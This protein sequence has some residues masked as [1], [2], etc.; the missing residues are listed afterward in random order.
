MIFVKYIITVVIVVFLSIKASHYV[1]L[2]D[3]KTNL[4]GAFLGGIMLSAVTS[5]PE[6]FTSL[7]S[8]FLVGEP[9]MCLG[10][11]LGSDLFNLAALATIILVYFKGFNK[12]VFSASYRMVA[13]AVL[14]IYV[15]LGLNF[16]GAINFSVFTVSLTS[17]FIIVTYAVGVKYLSAASD[18]ISDEEELKIQASKSSPLSVKQVG[19]RFFF[20]GLGII[21]FSILL[22][23]YTDQVAERLNIGAGFAGALFLGIATSLPEVTSTITL[24]KMKNYNIAIGNIIGSNLFNF[25][26]LAL[27]DVISLSEDLY[28][29]PDLQIKALEICGLIAMP[30]F[31]VLI[32]TRNKTLRAACSV[33]IIG[34]YLAFLLI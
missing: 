18:V 13:F 1:D 10:N 6:L 11:V 4:S 29:F 24:F 26:I 7:T 32:K 28:A 33:G 15:A 19:T 21:V 2:L 25:I 30:L 12:S 3:K 31:Y 9:D 20:A 34:S 5:L 23:E 27:A 22:T 8:V 14:A 16:I 17:L